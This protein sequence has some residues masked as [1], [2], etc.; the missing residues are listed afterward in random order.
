M[1]SLLMMV[2]DAVLRSC[3]SGVYF[4]AGVKRPMPAHC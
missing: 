1:E 3:Q 2:L 4:C